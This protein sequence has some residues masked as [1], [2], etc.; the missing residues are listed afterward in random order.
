MAVRLLPE[1]TP[2]QLERDDQQYALGGFA[3]LTGDA[4][5]LTLADPA[6]AE[7][8]RA[9]RALR[10]LETGRAIL[11][12][13][14]LDTR[15]DLSDLR[16]H[17]PELAARFADLRDRLDQPR[18][19][20]TLMRTRSGGTDLAADPSPDA[21]RDRHRLA[22]E[23][24]AVLDQIRSLPQFALFALPPATSELLAQAAA[25]PVVTFNVS[26]YGSDALLL[27][28]SGIAALELPGL[29]YDQ[30][31]EKIDSFR[32]A[33]DT[34]TDLDVSHAERRDAQKKLCGILEWM[35]DAA[36]GP[37]LHALGCRTTP[38]PGE[39]WPR[40]WWAPG[41]LLAMLPIHAAGYHSEP[42]GTQPRRTVMDRVV[43]SYTPTVRALRHAR[44]HGTVTSSSKRSLI[45]A[46]PVTP[47]GSELPNVPAEVAYV[48]SLVPDPVTL[49]EPQDA[50]SAAPSGSS[51]I[52]TR[53]AVLANL[54]DCT[55]AHFACHGAS[56][57]ADPSKS[58]LLL[59]DHDRDPL[60]VASLSSVNLSQARLAYLSACRTAYTPATT[61]IDEAIHLAT[62]FQ[63]AGFPHVI[64]TLWEINDQVAADVARTFYTS[65]CADAGSLDT[66]QAAQALHHAVRDLR[67]ALPR[68]P[69]LWA[70]YLHAGA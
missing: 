58:L 65:L 6:T 57:P 30:V 4:A 23:L 67:D 61:L 9:V 16:Q 2:R 56:N 21:A 66:T 18:D 43:S 13:Q 49:T 22:G 27:T 46:M 42:P 52:P 59:H 40:V 41:G 33:M 36:A 55:I 63:L 12:S 20:L 51:G 44:R 39:K 19:E 50:T 68:T 10:L 26:T 34:T 45:V 54:A 8:E 37:V 25:G 69:T 1:I 31:T 14:A 32:Q 5:A 28:E 17:H 60:T 53:A 29:A 38:A 7:G 64:G 48:Q 35:W 11:L 62:A 3:G 70:A 24:S 15:S 47:G